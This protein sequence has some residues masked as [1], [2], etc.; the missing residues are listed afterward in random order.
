[1]D[2]QLLQNQDGVLKISPSVLVSA[3]SVTVYKPDGAILVASTPAALDTT[4]KTIT[5][6]S[7]TNPNLI[8]LNNTTSLFVGLKY[9]IT[10]TDGQSFQVTI[11]DID[12]TANQITVNVPPSFALKNGDTLKG[13]QITHAIAA[14]SLSTLDT[15]YRAEFL[16]TETG[17]GQKFVETVFFDVVRMQFNIKSPELVKRLITF[18]FPSAASRFEAG[19]VEEIADRAHRMIIDKI[20]STGRFP[21]L[22]GSPDM[23]EEAYQYAVRLVLADFG[24]IP[25][26]GAVDIIEYMTLYRDKLYQSLEI[27]AQGNGYDADNDGAIEPLERLNWSTKIIL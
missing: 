13:S 27:A 1:M 17:T 10:G 7:A 15:Y 16:C 23:F 5:A 18:Q 2:L 8:T 24:M 12:D 6:Q 21:H 20:R 22:Y 19:M 11:S 4:S 25:N 26:A 14:A 3:C 9:I